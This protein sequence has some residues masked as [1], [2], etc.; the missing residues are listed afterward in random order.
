M[1]WDEFG[2]DDG[3]YIGNWGE[4]GWDG[5]RERCRRLD[6]CGAS[7]RQRPAAHVSGPAAVPRPPIPTI[8]NCPSRSASDG[9]VPPRLGLYLR[10]SL[11]IVINVI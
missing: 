4:N 9:E 11:L 7:K 1:K 5:W 8:S 2:R 10:I 3:S 6:E